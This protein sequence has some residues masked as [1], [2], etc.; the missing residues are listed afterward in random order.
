M[1]PV[2]AEECSDL[3]HDEHNGFYIENINDVTVKQTLIATDRTL[4]I[5]KVRQNKCSRRITL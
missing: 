2:K 1:P 3:N 4:R 5:F